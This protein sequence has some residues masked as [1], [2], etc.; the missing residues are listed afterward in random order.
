MAAT[1]ET[2][3]EAHGSGPFATFLAGVAIGVLVS[4]VIIPKLVG[5]TRTA[6]T[7]PVDWSI[8][9]LRAPLQMFRERA[10]RFPTDEEGL[11]ALRRAPAS[12]RPDQWDGP[13]LGEEPRDPWRQPF[14]YRASYEL[15]SKGPDRQEGTADDISSQ[16]RPDTERFY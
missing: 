4:A 13:Y 14:I 6:H 7:S 15:I 1:H 16:R 11:D 10:G 3:S 2:S 12:L 9:G 8:L 5:R